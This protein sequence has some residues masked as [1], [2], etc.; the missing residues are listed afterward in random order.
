MPVTAT[1]PMSGPYALE[2]FGDFA[3]TG[4][5]SLY[6]TLFY[7]LLATSYQH[8]YDNVY[9]SAS[10][11]AADFYE[12]AY[13]STIEG[14]LPSYTP[15]E[16]PNGIIAQGKL[17]QLALFNIDTPVTG[18]PIDPY[19]AIPPSDPQHPENEVYR[20]GFG[21]GNL[22]KNEVRV[23]YVSDAA[24]DPD[25][26]LQTLTFCL[27]NP[28]APAC[29]P[30]STNYGR[31]LAAPSYGLRSDLY[32]N[33]LRDW[34]PAAPV[35]LCG[36]FQ[37]PVVT[38]PVNT[39]LMGLWWQ[40]QGVPVAHTAAALATSLVAVLDLESGLGPGDPYAPLEA[41]FQ[42]AKQLLYQQGYQAAYDA[43]LAANPGDTAGADAAGIS[44]GQSN[45]A[46]NYHQSVGPFCQAAARGFFSNF[47][48]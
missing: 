33:D 29:I 7:P 36:G 18:T 12:A 41:G 21:T 45:V 20:L 35:L 22:V 42:Q 5:V 28:G 23:A 10:A 3:F 25:I 8:T 2:A 47:L 30:N 48:Q 40:G 37:D 19:L 15:V 13:A 39:G 27:A 31:A 38:F 46:Q 14:L 16:G 24:M 9:G 34:I 4:H 26:G 6:S 1:A 32:A 11:T 17:P 43:W 44:G